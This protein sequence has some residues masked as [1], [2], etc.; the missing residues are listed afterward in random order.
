VSF[1]KSDVAIFLHGSVVVLSNLKVCNLQV[2][3]I[4]LQMLLHLW[5]NVTD[6]VF[7]VRFICD[8]TSV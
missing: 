5:T 6:H 7:F 1:D 2:S 3:F 4:H 8:K